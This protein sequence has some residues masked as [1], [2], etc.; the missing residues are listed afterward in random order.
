VTTGTLDG[1]SLNSREEGYYRAPDSAH[2]IGDSQ[3][4]PLGLEQI[5]LGSRVWTRRASGWTAST[6]DVVCFTALDIIN[7]ILR[8]GG[9]HDDSAET[10]DGPPTGGES[11]RIYKWTYEDA[12]R[13]LISASERSLGDSPSEIE[14][15]E[16]VKETFSD[17]TATTELV[18]GENTG[19]VYSLVVTR[20]GPKMSDRSETVVD[21]YDEPVEIE[22]PPNVPAAADASASSDC[23]EP[24][25][26][27]P[28]IPAVAAAVLGPVLFLVATS[29]VWPRRI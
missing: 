3:D 15:H 20:D 28:W 2:V 4:S 24:A 18:V 5:V 12:G 10:G 21:Q 14:A 23:P 29:F 8:I 27:F 7:G 22:P 16:A 17:L 26:G 6:T 19:R 13:L 9:E 1:E 25:S 11:T